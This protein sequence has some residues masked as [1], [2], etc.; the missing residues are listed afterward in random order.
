MLPQETCD[1]IAGECPTPTL[2]EYFC[3]LPLVICLIALVF[4]GPVLGVY[5][6]PFVD[7]AWKKAKRLIWQKSLVKENYIQKI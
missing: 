6:R 5:A 1:L 7:W 4:I 2:F 3:G